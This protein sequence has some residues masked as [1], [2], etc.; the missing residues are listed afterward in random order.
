MKGYT[1]VGVIITIIIGLFLAIVV[2]LMIRGPSDATLQ[3]QKCVPPPSGIICANL[4]HEEAQKRGDSSLQ[5]MLA[6]DVIDCPEN[7]FE[8]PAKFCDKKKYDGQVYEV[9][10]CQK[11]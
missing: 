10:C 3:F 1:T 7:Y 11:K 9:K 2:F 5:D 4:A 6:G 8:Y